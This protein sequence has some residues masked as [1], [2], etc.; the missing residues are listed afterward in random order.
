MSITEAQDT[1][2]QLMADHAPHIIRINNDQQEV[3][4][5]RTCLEF[6]DMSDASAGMWVY[7]VGYLQQPKTTVPDE[8]VYFISQETDLDFLK[9]SQKL[10][11][12]DERLANVVS[13]DSSFVDSV[14]ESIQS[15]KLTMT[16]VAK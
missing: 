13:Y 12:V 8:K 6:S 3:P 5:I 11:P 4:D 14:L 15:G 7:R 1:I 10:Q 2:T 9:P 16:L